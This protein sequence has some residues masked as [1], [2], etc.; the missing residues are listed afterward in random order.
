[1][2]V[3]E[4]HFPE[5]YGPV[6]RLWRSIEK[7]VR[8]GRSDT[9]A[10]IQKKLARDPELFLVAEEAGQIIGTV[11][12]GYDGR[13]GIIY[14]LAVEASRRGQGIGT[15]LLAQVEARLRQLGCL[16]SYL[17]VT[18]DNEEAMRYYEHHGWHPMDHVRLYGKDLA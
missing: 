18:L 8:F 14:H 16:K 15:E 11:I 3:R 5:D 10:E 9:P 7:G 17:M 6:S 12:G 1:V 4:F 2:R 13:R